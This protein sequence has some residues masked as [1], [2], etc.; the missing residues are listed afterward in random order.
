MART[1]PDLNHAESWLFSDGA[2]TG[3]GSVC[4]GGLDEDGLPG[5]EV[6]ELSKVP[7]WKRCAQTK[8]V[9]CVSGGVRDFGVEVRVLWVDDPVGVPFVSSD[10]GFNQNA[11]IGKLSRTSWQITLSSSW[12]SRT[13]LIFLVV[14]LARY[15]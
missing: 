2:A 8:S 1:P 9:Q 5:S 13:Q 6:A 4:P 10:L 3:C 7:K 14:A 15:R 12:T 11:M